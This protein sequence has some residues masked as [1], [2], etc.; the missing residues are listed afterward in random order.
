MTRLNFVISKEEKAQFLD[1]FKKS[2]CKN[3]SEFLI[4]LLQIPDNGLEKVCKF[5][6]LAIID[7]TRKNMVIEAIDEPAAKNALLELHPRATIH[8]C[9]KQ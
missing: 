6:I 8:Q 3:Q 4:K 1:G 7:G 2:G 5:N 9:N